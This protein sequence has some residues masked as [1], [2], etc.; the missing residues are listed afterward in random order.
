MSMAITIQNDCRYGNWER[1]AALLSHFGISQAPPEH[2][3]KAFENSYSV[4]FLY[5]GERFIGFGRSIS[6]GVAQA[7]LFNIVVDPDYHG[8]GL[9]RL[10]IDDLLKAVGHCN[11]VLY[12]HPN[13][14]SFY[15]HLGF[16]R[17]KTG[18]ARYQSVEKME[19]MDFIE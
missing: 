14:V 11:V 8:Q 16:R 18:M 1:I 2:H 9:G 3:R 6:D 15:R 10:I 12:T 5:D 19:E 4:T 17:M 7:A 13:T